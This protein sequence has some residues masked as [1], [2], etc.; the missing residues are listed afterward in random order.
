[1]LEKH[2]LSDQ[3]IIKSL[4]TNYGITIATLTFLPIGA[5]TNASIYK[6]QTFDQTTYRAENNHIHHIFSEVSI[7]AK[8]FFEKWGFRIVT[9]QTI[10]RKN[11]ELTNF[12]MERTV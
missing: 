8:L 4:N 6:A 11:V 2:A 5:D 7:T 3:I 9:Q 12:K 1:M 10:V